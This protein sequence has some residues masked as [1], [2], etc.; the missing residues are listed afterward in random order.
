MVWVR[1]LVLALMLAAGSTAAAE[2]GRPKLDDKSFRQSLVLV[3]KNEAQLKAQCGA[4]LPIV[5]TLV[6]DV[7]VVVGQDFADRTGLVRIGAG[8]QYGLSDGELYSIAYENLQRRAAKVNLLTFG[9][10]KAIAFDETYNASLLLL[11]AVWDKLGEPKGDDMVVAVPGRDIVAFGSS[12]DRD[13]VAALR[14]IAAMPDNG[15]PITRKLLR[16]SGADWVIYE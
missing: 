11:P 6:G 16:R 8:R 14:Q 7:V 10:V 4:C 15:F 5:H 13:T 1:A 9:D 3:V 2:P 12:R